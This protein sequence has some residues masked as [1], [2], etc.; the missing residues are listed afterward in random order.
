[1]KDKHFLKEDFLIGQ[2]F[3]EWKEQSIF[4]GGKIIM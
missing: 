4:F 2:K 3:E 1:M